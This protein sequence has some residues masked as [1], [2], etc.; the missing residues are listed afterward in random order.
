MFALVAGHRDARAQQTIRSA[1]VAITSAKIYMDYE[2]WDDA[3]SAIK[4]GLALEPENAELLSLLGQV[5]AQQKQYARADSAFKKSVL[6]DPTKAEEVGQTRER[7]YKIIMR[8]GLLALK[9]S[10]KFDSLARM[11]AGAKG[12]AGDAPEEGAESPDSLTAKR[13]RNLALAEGLFRNATEFW[14]ERADGHIQL[15]VICFRR[16]DYPCAVERFRTA[17]LIA[18]RDPSILRNLATSYSLSRQPDSAIATYK[19]LLAVEPDDL[20]TQ[21]S[22]ATLFL[23][24]GKYDEAGAMYDSILAGREV[25]DPN[26]LYNA[27]VAYAQTKQYEKASK[28]FEEVLTFVPDDLDAMVNLSIIYIQTDNHEKSIPLLE[29]LTKIDPQNP[30]YW[31]YLAIAYTKAK[32]DSEA[33]AAYSKYKELTGGK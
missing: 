26:M 17:R 2:K 3:L 11:A 29:K 8:D 25:D 16:E 21:T 15:G 31:N 28:Y 19:A 14:P 7:F 12:G 5:S 24:S 20:D 1:K 18:P 23:N 32:K 30:E 22:I 6:L 9:E 4:Q 27:G 33:Q 13:D 10:T